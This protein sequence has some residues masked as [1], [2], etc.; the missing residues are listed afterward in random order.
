M[1][2]RT[3]SNSIQL[4]NLASD[5]HRLLFTWAIAHLDR[6][7]KMSGDPRVFRGIV[8]PMLGH[9]NEAACARAMVDMVK[10]G[11]AC[12][13]EDERGQ[14]VILFTG[15]EEQQAGMR[16]DREPKSKFGAPPSDGARTK[17]GYVPAWLRRAAG[18]DPAQCRLNIA[19]PPDL[20]GRTDPEEQNPLH[21]RQDAG[22]KPAQSRQDAAINEGKGNEG[23]GIEAAREDT[24]PAA[25][26]DVGEP[27]TERTE[28]PPLQLET[29]DPPESRGRKREPESTRVPE[30]WKPPEHLYA[31]GEA[32]PAVR[33]AEHVQRAQVAVFVDHYRRMPGRRGYMADWTAA[34]RN[35]LRKHREFHPDAP[36]PQVV[37]PSK[38]PPPP[39]PLLEFRRKQAEAGINYA[40]TQG[41]VEAGLESRLQTEIA[42][43]RRGQ[44]A[45]SGQLPV[46][47]AQS[48]AKSSSV[49]EADAALGAVK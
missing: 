15:F 40:P 7:G 22:T 41:S 16:Y 2:N 28:T 8:C 25:P 42:M 13:Y 6:D 30:D 37:G 48:N 20:F 24:L 29:T 17:P 9:V 43:M 31:W 38:P 1:L 32:E 49:G 4:V 33:L 26:T 36:E 23:K 35:W 47:D 10:C 34:W 21:C 44:R 12:A 3:I 11:L 19:N 5:T 39:A 27:D 45:E 18:D 14:L 46:S